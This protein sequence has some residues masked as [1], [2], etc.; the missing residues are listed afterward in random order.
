MFPKPAPE[1]EMTL[2]GQFREP[3]PP[4]LFD[5]LMRTAIVVAVLSGFL[6][7]VGLMVWFALL[8]IPVAIG[9]AL[10]AWVIYRF[11][12]WRVRHSFTGQRDVFRP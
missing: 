7:V 4:S 5:R 6:A 12:L 11:Q 10:V 1:I 3:P 2:D 9:A 8:M